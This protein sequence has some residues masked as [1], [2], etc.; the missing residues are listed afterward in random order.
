MTEAR[1]VT[2]VTRFSGGPGRERE[3]AEAWAFELTYYFK[4]GVGEQP[5]VTYDADAGV[6]TCTGLMATTHPY[7]TSPVTVFD[8][9]SDPWSLDFCADAARQERVRELYPRAGYWWDCREHR[10]PDPA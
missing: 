3:A 2:A 8:A 1:L 10:S 5:V 7:D 4:R 6:Y 9:N